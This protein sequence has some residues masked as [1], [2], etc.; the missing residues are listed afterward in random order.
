MYVFF[1]DSPWLFTQ[2]VRCLTVSVVIIFGLLEFM[3]IALLKGKHYLLKIL[4]DQSCKVCLVSDSV[5][6]VYMSSNSFQH[7]SAVLLSWVA[8]SNSF[9]VG[10]AILIM[11]I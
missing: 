10:A 6:S 5:S 1:F 7:F 4:Q 9:T 3:G 8:F 11:L 2:Q